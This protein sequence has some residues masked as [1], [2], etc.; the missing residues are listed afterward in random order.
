MRGVKALKTTPSV[1]DTSY[2]AVR[3]QNL[4][5]AYPGHLPVI[6]NLSLILPAGSRCLL[7]GANGAGK[8]SLLQILAGKHLVEQEAVRILGRSAFHDIVGLLP[9]R[10]HALCS[11][12][13][14]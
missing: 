6:E 5:Y 9:P 4:T 1:Q 8:S 13:P 14:R 7:I 11:S 3:V 2:D 10:M 12:E